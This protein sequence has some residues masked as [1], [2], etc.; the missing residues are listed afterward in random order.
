MHRG[1]FDS[2][3]TPDYFLSVMSLRGIAMWLILL[4]VS[5]SSRNDFSCKVTFRDQRFNSEQFSASSIS[6][7]PFVRNG[8]FDTTNSISDEKIV[9][10][11]TEKR[12]DLAVGHVNDAEVNKNDSVTSCFGNIVN[13]DHEALRTDSAVWDKIGSDYAVV[14]YILNSGRVKTP[15]NKVI[16]RVEIEA[17]IWSVNSPAL[18]WRAELKRTE[19]N[20]RTTDEECIRR[21]VQML[22]DLLPPYRP[23]LKEKE[24]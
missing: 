4:S 24:W 9:L 7:F 23:V 13:R 1:L 6:V 19:Q 12:S 22:L 21:G 5:A 15:E 8:H 20:A 11:I 16:R 2:R 14:L 17:D 3:K 10:W 18:L